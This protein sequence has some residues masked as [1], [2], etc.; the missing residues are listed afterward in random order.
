[1]KRNKLALFLAC[2]FLIG[3]VFAFAAAEAPA[4]GFDGGMI[5]GICLDGDTLYAA[6]ALNK[7]VW[8]REDGRTEIFAG[9]RQYRDING[10]VIGSYLDGESS[11]AC[12]AEPWA[13]VPFLDG[14]AVSDAGANAVRYIAGGKVMTAAGAKEAG[15]LD[16]FCTDARLSRPT[17]LAVDGEG[18]L[19]IADTGNGAIRRLDTEGNL[20]TVMTGLEEPTGLCW[21]DGALYIAETGRSRILCVKDDK[22]EVLAGNGGEKDESGVYGYGYADGP[23][24]AALFEHPQGIAVADDGAVYIADTGNGAVRKLVDGQVSTI[25]V[26]SEDDLNLVSPR[27]ILV[28]GTRLLVSDSFTGAILEYDTVNQ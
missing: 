4:S 8:R 18:C 20:S 12:F 14:Y 9:S 27:G 21:H 26:T 2:V 1:M 19:Y 25:A 7:V 5:S 16:G 15:F 6:D 28:S 24:D 23:A 3:A 17:G 13:I 11:A 22:E 10:Q